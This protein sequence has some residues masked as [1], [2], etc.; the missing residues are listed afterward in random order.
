M[1]CWSLFGRKSHNEGAR[2]ED[3]WCIFQIR[4]E[5]ASGPLCKKRS[6]SGVSPCQ[7]S[8]KRSVRIVRYTR[9]I[10]GARCRSSVPAIPMQLAE[11]V[12]GVGSDNLPRRAVAVTF[13]DGYA[14]NLYNAKPILTALDVPATVFV[15]TGN[16]GKQFWWDEL[17]CAV[18]GVEALIEKLNR[19]DREPLAKRSLA[20]VRRVHSSEK[21]CG[22]KN[23]RRS[24]LAP[25]AARSTNKRTGSGSEPAE[26]AGC[27]RGR[28]AASAGLF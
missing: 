22:S 24:C 12:A 21:K 3:A 17:D 6:N 5:L 2:R 15:T 27:E 1:S 18:D 26:N 13:D 11:L 9:T 4:S 28:A 8:P 10:H 19:L 16:L 20:L 23:P 25:N 14:D 7:R